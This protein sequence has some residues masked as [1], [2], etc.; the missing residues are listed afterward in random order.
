MYQ[1]GWYCAFAIGTAQDL[2]RAA[3]HSAVHERGVQLVEAAG[4]EG[5][6]HLR[7]DLLV[8]DRGGFLAYPA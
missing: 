3:P 1:S 2:L 4:G 5:L 7:R 6:D 8:D